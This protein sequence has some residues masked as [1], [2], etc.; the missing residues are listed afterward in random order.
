MM[1]QLFKKNKEI[2]ISSQ[3]YFLIQNVWAKKMS[4]VTSDLSKQSLVCCL[5]L[6]VIISAKICIYNIYSGFYPKDYN[7]VF[8]GSQPNYIIVTKPILDNTTRTEFPKVELIKVTRFSFY[9]DSLKKSE[10][11]KIIYDS[12]KNYRPGLLDS[13]A[14]IENYYKMK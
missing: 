1:W 9:L 3:Y 13:L 7:S 14:F 4:A 12:I 2:R 11:G 5:I 10:E 6:F 8:I